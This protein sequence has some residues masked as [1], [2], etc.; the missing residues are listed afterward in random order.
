MVVTRELELGYFGR[1]ASE[2]LSRLSGS[3]GGGSLE[4]SVGEVGAVVSLA[5]EGCRWSGGVNT[6]VVQSRYVR[7]EGALI[8]LIC[9]ADRGLCV[10]SGTENLG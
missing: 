7:V 4:T 2:V 1:R 3:Y 5:V 10:V 8:Y 6:A 9:M